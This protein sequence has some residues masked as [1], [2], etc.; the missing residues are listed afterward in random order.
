[1]ML[2]PLAE[3]NIAALSSTHIAKYRYGR[4]KE[5]IPIKLG[6]NGLDLLQ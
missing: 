5:V 2:R 6:A 4:L 3:L 1:M